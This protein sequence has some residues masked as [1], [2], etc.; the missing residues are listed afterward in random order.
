MMVGYWNS[1][2]QTLITLIP[3]IIKLFEIKLTGGPQNKT[4][5]FNQENTKFM[6]FIIW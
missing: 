5:F 3:N 6:Q 4:Y 1:L 2:L